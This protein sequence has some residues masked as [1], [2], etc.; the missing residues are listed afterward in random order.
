MSVPE[1]SSPPRPAYT[2]MPRCDRRDPPYQNLDRCYYECSPGCYRVDS[3]WLLNWKTCDG[4]HWTGI[5]IVC[6]GCCSLPP[7]PKDTYMNCGIS[8]AEAYKEGT[9]CSYYCSLYWHIPDYG[10]TTRTCSKGVWTGTD[11]VCKRKEGEPPVCSSPPR[12]ANAIR[13][14]CSSSPPTSH[15]VYCRYECIPGYFHRGGNILRTCIN[16]VWDG[17]DTV[18]VRNEAFCCIVESELFSR[19]CRVLPGADDAGLDA[20]RCGADLPGTLGAEV[21]AYHPQQYDNNLHC[22]WTI[23]VSVG[24]LVGLRPHLFSLE[25]GYDWLDVYKGPLDNPILLGS[26]T[27]TDI[28]AALIATSN[29]IHLLFRT[30]V[31]NFDVY[32]GFKIYFQGQIIP[33]EVIVTSKMAHLVLTI[34]Q[35]NADDSFKIHFEDFYQTFCGWSLPPV[36]VS[37]A[38]VLG[39]HFHSDESG[40]GAGFSGNSGTGFKIH[41][42]L[43]DK[44]EDDRQGYQR[45]HQQTEDTGTFSSMNYPHYP[46]HNHVYQQ[47]NI[48]VD[49]HKAVK[50]TLVFIDTQLQD[51]PGHCR[52]DYV[53]VA[54]PS[55]E[56]KSLYWC[57]TCVHHSASTITSVEHRPPAPAVLDAISNWLLVSD[58]I[59]QISVSAATNQVW[60]L[61]DVGRPLRRTGVTKTTPQGTGWEVVGTE[62]FLQI[63][64]GHVGVWAVYNH[65]TLMYRVGTYGNSET[66]GLRWQEVQIDDVYNALFSFEKLTSRLLRW[67]LEIEWIH[68]GKNLVW[69]I[70]SYQHWIKPGETIVL[71]GI[72]PEA[73]D[74]GIWTTVGAA[75]VRVISVSSVTGQLWAVGRSGRMW[76]SRFY[77]EISAKY[78]WEMISGCFTSVSVG[79]AGVWAVDDVGSVYHRAGTFLNETSPGEEWVHVPGVNLRQVAVGDGI[80]WGVDSN[81]RVFANVLPAPVGREVCQVGL[82]GRSMCYAVQKE[83]RLCAKDEIICP[84]SEKCIPECSVCDGIVD[85]G[86]YDDTDERNCCTRPRFAGCPEKHRR[87]CT[88]DAGCYSPSRV[89]DGDWNCREDKE[90]ERDCFGTVQFYTGGTVSEWFSSTRAGMSRYDSVLHGRDCFGMVQFYTGGTVPVWFSST[91]A[92]LSWYGSVLHGWDCPGMVQFYT[93]GIVTVWFSSTRAGM[94]RYGSVLHGRDC[95]SMVQFYTGGTVSVWF[96][97]TQAGLFRYGS[98]RH[99]LDW[100]G[101][102]QF[103]TGGTVSVWF[104]HTRA[105]LSQYGSVL[106]RAG[107]SQYGSV[108]QGA[109]LSWY[110]SVRQGRDCPGMVPFYTGGTAPVW[111]SS[112]RAGL[113][114]YGS[115]LHG[116]D[117]FGMVQF[118]TG[119]TVPV[120]F[121]STQAGL[122]RYGSVLH[123]RDCPSMVQ[124]YTG[125]TVSCISRQERCDGWADCRDFSDEIGCGYCGEYGIPFFNQWFSAL[126]PGIT[127]KMLLSPVG[128]IPNDVVCDG[129][130]DFVGLPGFHDEADC[131]QVRLYEAYGVNYYNMRSEGLVYDHTCST[132]ECTSSFFFCNDENEFECGNWEDEQ[133]CAQTLCRDTQLDHRTLK[134]ISIAQYCDGED[135]CR[136]GADESPRKCGRGACLLPVSLLQEKFSIEE[137][138]GTHQ[139][140]H[141]SQELTLTDWVIE[142]RDDWLQITLEEPVQLTGVVVTGLW[143]SQTLTFSL[144]YGVWADCLAAYTEQDGQ[145]SNF[146]SSAG[147]DEHYLA[148]AV[149]AKVVRLTPESW[150]GRTTWGVGLLGCPVKEDRIK[151][152]SCGKGWTMFEERCYQKFPSPLV[153]WAAERYCQALGG[154]LAA[155]NTPQENG[156]LRD[157]IGN[158]WIGMKIDA[159]VIKNKIQEIVNF[160]WSDGSP[161][162][163]AFKKQNISFDDFQEYIWRLNDPF[164]GFLEDHDQASYRGDGCETTPNYTELGHTEDATRDELHVYI[165][166]MTACDDCMARESSCGYVRCGIPDQYRCGLIYS[167]GYPHAFPSS[168]ICL[169][170]ID[171]PLGSYVTLVLLD[172]DLPCTSRELQVRDRFLTVGWNT[173]HGLCRGEGEQ[174]RYVSSSNEMI[175]VMLATSHR[176]DFGASR[177][178]MA[179]F[180]VSAFSPSRQVKH[181][182]EDAGKNYI[183]LKKKTK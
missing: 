102:V 162:G 123:G 170:T 63:S 182:P 118:Y 72:S 142:G 169:W 10:S 101:M 166:D 42:Y 155:V 121:S 2:S 109:G 74:K 46:Y 51:D 173:I 139:I 138:I 160:T 88:G 7:W 120:W 71:K 95:P 16:G 93:S 145:K 13:K 110:G 159:V 76:R 77:C 98:V 163:D 82:K 26:Y 100:F 19:Q 119:G 128:C 5:D 105:G 9:V 6:A 177:G 153:W 49:T 78:D 115:V 129:V 117:C 96:S 140:I 135:D 8:Y 165:P 86:D 60:A 29:M 130:I 43:Q 124:F 131:V 146:T 39:I 11:L 48:T 81:N 171:G 178:F 151:H 22:T 180:N 18:C 136:T 154:H 107:L 28:P 40:T 141:S 152:K 35:A 125:G 114:R 68:S 127:D 161:A 111:F 59:K 90:D 158:G 157:N 32:V 112:K 65:S 62:R 97:S 181:L 176:T 94:S 85:C 15:G 44:S 47:W 126:D 164:C 113:S 144:K 57:G 175:L 53:K 45:M 30:D 17:R 3:K 55:D 168:A 37:M 56:Q 80:V 54:D 67:D 34:S 61:D 147:K 132:G 134:E 66:A 4:G 12:P 104:I 148:T 38:P 14:Y 87:V 106:T 75:T 58:G 31:I 73:P 70:G 52:N 83:N 122:S 167:P 149:P 156:F 50:L 108:L 150:L 20:C 84:H 133:E 25:A 116:R 27:G 99:G 91:R 24:E 179:T 183:R 21:V 143:P 103:Y 89:C 79:P 36:Y 172:V 69:V 137:G 41:Y 23:E 33:A 1:C 174:K 92:E 64:V